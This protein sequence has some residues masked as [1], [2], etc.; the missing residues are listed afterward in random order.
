MGSDED[1]SSVV[2]DAKRP[3]L[4]V[5]ASAGPDSREDAQ[6]DDLSDDVLERDGKP[7]AEPG[8]KKSAHLGLSSQSF[9]EREDVREEISQ[10]LALNRLAKRERRPS[11]ERQWE[12]DS[13]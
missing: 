3:R 7:A 8:A 10:G 9:G 6:Q 1:R 5:G 13:R 4:G 12:G 2:L 11:R